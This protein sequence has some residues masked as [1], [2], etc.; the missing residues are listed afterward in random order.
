MNKRA[1]SPSD[2]IIC[3]PAFIGGTKRFSKTSKFPPT[4]EGFAFKR[5]A[6][7]VPAA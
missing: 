4:L 2:K 3:T 7:P 5:W 6:T 1:V